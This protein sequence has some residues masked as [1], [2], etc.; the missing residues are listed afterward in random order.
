MEK[1]I[2]VGWARYSFIRKVAKQGRIYLI[3]IP[4]ELG[5]RLHKKTVLVTIEPIK[6]LKEVDK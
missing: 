4:R 6:E 1:D 5:Q 2:V 3:V